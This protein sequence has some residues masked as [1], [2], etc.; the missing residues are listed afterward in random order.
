MVPKST[1]SFLGARGESWFVVTACL[2]SAK[3]ALAT[4]HPNQARDASPVTNT[5]Q[6]KV[7][8]HGKGL[9]FSS[10]MSTI[11]YTENGVSPPLLA[12]GFFC[13]ALWASRL[14]G[15]AGDVT[16]ASRLRHARLA[17]GLDSVH[18]GLANFPPFPPFKL[19]YK[20]GGSHENLKRF[21]E[22]LVGLAGWC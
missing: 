20:P 14:F 10:M 7:D 5:T 12:E 16:R 13:G 1:V 6:L 22:L 2:R 15:D 3:W 18:L 11:Q 4:R 17:P 9:E 8:Q 21:G 19:F